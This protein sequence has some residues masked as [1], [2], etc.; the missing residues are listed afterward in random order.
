MADHDDRSQPYHDCPVNEP[1]FLDPLAAR[2]GVGDCREPQ[3]SEQE[4]H[5]DRGQADRRIDKTR[6]KDPRPATQ[7]VGQKEQ[8]NHG[9]RG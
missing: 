7:F 3:R 5:H 1:M 9:R 2:K 4:H 6:H 8:D